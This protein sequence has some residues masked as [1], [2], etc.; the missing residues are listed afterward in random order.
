MPFLKKKKKN[1]ISYSMEPLLKYICPFT[2]L[3]PTQCAEKERGFELVPGVLV[4]PD[5][6]TTSKDKLN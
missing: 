1:I 6:C 3:I 5:W 4:N 2:I